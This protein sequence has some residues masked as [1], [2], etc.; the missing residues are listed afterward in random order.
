MGYIAFD[1]DAEMAESKREDPSLIC[2]KYELPDGQVIDINEERFQCAEIMFNPTMINAEKYKSSKGIHE[3]LYSSILKCDKDI[4]YDLFQNIVLSGGNMIFKG[5]DDRL[6]K[7]LRKLEP[8]GYRVKIETNQNKYK[9][10]YGY[11]RECDEYIYPE[12]SQ[13]I[14]NNFNDPSTGGFMDESD[15]LSR[16]LG[17]RRYNSFIGGSLLAS[18]ECR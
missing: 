18:R 1:Y 3:M 14:Y 10:L 9:L 4:Q 5:M 15:V 17:V 11:L 6:T 12:I 13:I 16:E 8:K 2:R 7:E